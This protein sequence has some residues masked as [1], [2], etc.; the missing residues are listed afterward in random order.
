MKSGVAIYGGFAGTET[1][2]TQRNWVANLTVLSGEIGLITT[3]TD[4]SKTVVSNSSVNS[5][6][7]LDGFTVQGGYFGIAEGTGGGGIYN[8]NS[9]PIISNCTISGNTA[10]FGAGVYNTS[11]SSPTISNCIITNNTAKGGGGIYNDGS[12][13][14]IVTNCK[15]TYNSA[16]LDGGGVYSENSSS[17]TLINCTISDNTSLQFGGGVFNNLASTTTLYNSIIW[18]NA[19]ATDGKQI[20]VGGVSSSVTLNYSCYANGANDVLNNVA[21]FTATNNN[22][23]TYPQFVNSGASDYRIVGTSP[24]ADAGF[25]AYNSEPNDIRGAGFDRK[26][27]KLNGSVG[28]IDMGAYEYKF[29]TDPAGGTTYTW[30]GTT[31]TDWNNINNWSTS[32]VP[33]SADGAIISSPAS[34]FPVI[35]ANVLCSG[36]TI[37]SGASVTVTSGGTITVN[38]ILTN[39]GAITILSDAGGTGSLIAG[40]TSGTGSTTAERYMT[41]GAWHLVSSPLSGQT[42]AGFLTA[43]GNIATNGANRGMMDYNPALNLWNSFFT[44]ATGGNLGGGKGFSMRV[45]ATSAAVTFAGPLQAGTISL[46]TVPDMWNCVGNPY[47]SAIGI[48]TGSSST[49]NFLAANGSYL[50]PVYGAIYVW[51]NGDANNGQTG[52]YTAISNVSPPYNTVQQG[53]AFMVKMKVLVGSLSFTQSMQLHSTTLPLKSAKG[54]WP[55]I[56]LAA[57]VNNQKSSTIIAFNGEMTNGLD[58]T[59]D[60]GLFKGG[61]DLAVYTLLVEDNGYSFA[62][63]AL[64]DNDYNSMIIPVGIDSKTGGQVVFSAELLNLPSDCLVIL[65]DKVSKTFTDLSKNVYTTTIEANTSTSDRFR[66]HTSYLTTGISNETRTGQM[67]AYSIRNTE[68]RVNGSVSKLA[69]ATLYDIQGRVVL[70]KNLEEGSLN[71]IRTP[72]I[73]AGIYMLSV[74]DNQRVNRF[75]IPVRE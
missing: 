15:I 1:L 30:S 10:S 47:T 34:F 7:I 55:T 18:G 3:K 59:Y 57:S 67:S 75:K 24:C 53:Q 56:K 70:V 5:T 74:K 71:I 6:G 28:T 13:A 64:P 26:L 68:I 51:D 14:P 35:S 40:N 9:S 4:N 49:G 42:V 52:F 20:Y 63:Q 19:A 50:D 31:S 37:A 32:V 21:T 16:S 12:S 17:P 23:I 58:P 43:N 66:I 73:K 69:I 25:D 54:L 62:I 39:N 65:E 11:S 8:L 61:A 22:I 60:A 38:G 33:A 72:N 45:G 41:T 2:V 29:G 44:N 27:N 46:A 36:L 48:S